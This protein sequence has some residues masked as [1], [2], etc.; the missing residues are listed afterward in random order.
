MKAI[1]RL[2]YKAVELHTKI[3]KVIYDNNDDG[4]ID[5]LGLD[6]KEFQKTLPS[7]EVVYEYDIVELLSRVEPG[8]WDDDEEGEP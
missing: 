8:L 4:F 7:G 3:M 6:P 1:D 2:I 5:A